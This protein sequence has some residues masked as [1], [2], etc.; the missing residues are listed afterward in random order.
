MKALRL[1]GHRDLRIDDVDEPRLQPRWSIVQVDWSSI[2][3]SDVK[4]YLG[5]F[6]ISTEPN[7][8]TGVSMPVT[9]GHE[10]AGRVV[11]TDGSRPDI[12][13]G[14]R[15]TV[16]CAIK[17]E[18]CWYCRHGDYDLC[19]NLAILGFSAH[20]GMAELVAVPSYGLYK[21]PDSVSDEAGAIIE[22]LSVVVHAVRRGRL[23]PGDIVAIVGGGMIGLATAAVARSSAASA[24]YLVEQLPQ[25]RERAKQLGATVID[26]AQGSPVDQLRELTAGY[27]ADLAFDC[28]GTPDSLK[29]AI[30]LARKSGRVAV[31]GVFKAPPTVDMNSI[32][33][34]ER[35]LIGCMGP[36]E[37]FP[38]AISLV[39]DGRLN[40][41]DFITDKISYRDAVDHGFHKLIDEP[42][43][44]VRI[45]MNFDS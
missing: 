14:D 27:N 21:L 5:P 28:A 35:E 9:L 34:E 4:E 18:T 16:D 42:D 3:G 7:P 26:P 45:I 1:H 15:V 19:D 12:R 40:P 32:V 10:F 43:R 29:L 30:N 20:G 6:G 37:C 36:V 17:D 23:T 13:V 38:R 22:P 2:C 33:L 24:V 41:D 31:I 11:A 8:V 44:H 39:A 25:R